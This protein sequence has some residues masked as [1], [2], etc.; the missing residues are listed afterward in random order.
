MVMVGSITLAKDR[1]F[2]NIWRPI[3]RRMLLL[4]VRQKRRKLSTVVS[5]LIENLRPEAQTVALEI[6]GESES[7]KRI[8]FNRQDISF[9]KP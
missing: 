3:L 4:L 7:N 9:L 5:E 2:L 1:S 6:F 8:S